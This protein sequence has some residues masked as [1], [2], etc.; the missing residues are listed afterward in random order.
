[1]KQFSGVVSTQARNANVTTTHRRIVTVFFFTAA[2]HVGSVCVNRKGE[3]VPC[4][5]TTM[6]N[7]AYLVLS[8]FWAGTY[9]FNVGKA[10]S[11][12]VQNVFI[13][14]LCKNCL[15]ISKLQM[16]TQVSILNLQEFVRRRMFETSYCHVP[17]STSHSWALNPYLSCHAVSWKVALSKLYA[18]HPTSG[19]IIALSGPSI[20][21]K[22]L[23][24]VFQNNVPCGFYRV[25]CVVD[26]LLLWLKLRHHSERP[27]VAYP[28]VFRPSLSS[29]G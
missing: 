23:Q 16:N 27:D 25:A 24:N 29:A 13:E 1:M 21:N 15:A 12:K 20:L 18:T 8:L 4:W 7:N 10:S 19:Y 2:R 5:R 6:A 17:S 11:S 22:N 28:Q 9:L 3:A 26:A 14:V